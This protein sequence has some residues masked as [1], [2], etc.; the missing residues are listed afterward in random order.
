MVSA[1]ARSVALRVGDA[2]GGGGGGDLARSI[3]EGG[4]GRREGDFA[5]RADFAGLGGVVVGGRVDFGSGFAGAGRSAVAARAREGWAA[6]LAAALADVG[7]VEPTFGGAGR[8]GFAELGFAGFG[9]APSGE[10]G[11]VVGGG[12]TAG[13]FAEVGGTA[14]AFAEAVGGTAGAFAEAGEPAVGGAGTRGLASLL[15]LLGATGVADACARAGVAEEEVAL[16]GGA[17]AAFVAPAGESPV[18]VR[19][20]SSELLAD[21]ARFGTDVDFSSGCRA[22]I[23]AASPCEALAV[24]SSCASPVV[25]AFRVASGGT[26][27]I[28]R[29]GNAGSRTRARRAV[30]DPPTVP[31]SSA[32][33]ER[34]ATATAGSGR[35]G[36]GRGWI[37]KGI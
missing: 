26:A 27:A 14:G 11:P 37:R 25:R 18:A 6:V 20:A 7:G 31:S 5:G 22:A 24:R 19:G 2:A 21:P 1:W 9:G 28:P 3:R 36:A 23:S 34:T 10:R 17:W 30:I 15:A 29:S 12:G 16:Y 33:T 35:G 8:T 32:S 13:A 4:G